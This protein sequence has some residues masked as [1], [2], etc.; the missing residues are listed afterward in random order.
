MDIET[1]IEMTVL[2]EVQVGPGKDNT[3]ETL[4]GKIK[5]AVD[6]GQIQGPIPIEIESDVLNVGN[7][8]ILPMTVLTQRWKKNQNNYR[9]CTI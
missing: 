8:T 9:K 6:Q 4:V 5:A 3:Q 2:E 1:T 7:M